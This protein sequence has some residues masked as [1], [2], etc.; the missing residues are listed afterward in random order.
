[1]VVGIGGMWC[2]SGGGDGDRDLNRC[3]FFWDEEDRWT[4]D[5]KCYGDGYLGDN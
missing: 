3:I 2:G 5:T 1:M 4:L